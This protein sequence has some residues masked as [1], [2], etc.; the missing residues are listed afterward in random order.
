MH[1]TLLKQLELILLGCTLYVFSTGLASRK[2]TLLTLLGS[3][4]TS[5][6]K[7][8]YLPQGNNL[9]SLCGENLEPL[10]GN[11][12]SINYTPHQDA[13]CILTLR[14]TPCLTVLTFWHRASSM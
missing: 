7:K 11:S 14:T 6:V 4:L 13:L 2:E 5:S 12:W 8:Q 10:E 9:H 3:K 1:S